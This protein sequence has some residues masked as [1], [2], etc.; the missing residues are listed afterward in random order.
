MINPIKAYANLNQ[1]NRRWVAFGAGAAATLTG[2]IALLT[3]IAYGAAIADGF[4]FHREKK[5]AA[6][7]RAG[8][9][10]LV[11]ACAGGALV[12]NAFET[13]APVAEAPAPIEQ[14]VEV[15]VAPVEPV[16]E[17]PAP[18]PNYEYP[19]VAAAQKEMCEAGKQYLGDVL[20]RWATIDQAKEEVR[21]YSTYLSRNSPASKSDLMAVGMGC[22]RLWDL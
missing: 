6:R 3:P 19:T 15:P 22:S 1:A 5:V 4:H 7:I 20:G 10:T 11:V 16:V 17:V 12:P 14:V 8:F 13:T 21:S 18:A 9:V 2:S